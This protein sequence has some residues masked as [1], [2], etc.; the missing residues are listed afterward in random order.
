MTVIP[1]IELASAPPRRPSAPPAPETLSDTGI[2]NESII[3]LVFKTLHVQGARTGQQLAD[4]LCLPFT[5]L[6]ELLLDIQQR[7]FIE[8][9]GVTGHGRVSYTFELTGSGR[10]RARAALEANQYVGPVPVPLDQYRTWLDRQTIRNVHVN[11]ARVTEGF[12]EMVMDPTLL[13]TLGPAVNSAKSLFL[14]GDPGNG[15]T[16]IAESISRM[17]GGALYIPHAVDIGGQVMVVR[18]P[19]FHHPAEAE[20]DELADASPLW[21]RTEGEHD[22]RFARVRRPVVMV[23]GELTLDQLDLQYDEHTKMYQAP[24]QVKANGGVLI[25]DDFGRQRVP[26]RDLLNRWIVPLEK[27]TDYLSLHT[28]SKFSVP[29][30]CLLIFATNLDPR[31]LVEEAFLRRIHYKIYVPSP[32]RDQYAAIFERVCAA[33]SIPYSERGVDYVFERFYG[34]RG[35]PP[36]AC[37]PRDISEH[38]LDVARFLDR[39][40]ALDTDLLEAACESY[41]LDMAALAAQAETPS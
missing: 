8:V 21:R 26:P 34:D 25:I 10:D 30:D 9:R 24:F 1:E 37:H 13:E 27:R 23:G 20:E 29:F 6:D 4:S 35:I 17:M 33:M 22:R 32:T 2:S 19:V 31:D 40:P 3:D 36:R 7:R 38:V 41:F 39:E 11:R 18:D 5:L 12:R 14:Y 15:K 28:G 16:L